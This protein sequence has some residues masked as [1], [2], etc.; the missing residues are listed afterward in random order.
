MILSCSLRWPIAVITLFLVTTV[1]AVEPDKGPDAKDNGPDAKSAQPEKKHVAAE[2]SASKTL[3]ATNAGSRKAVAED[4]KF[5]EQHVRPLLINKCFE[6]HAGEES[7]GGLKLDSSSAL[8]RGGDSGAL[9]SAGDPDGSLLVSAIRYDGL[10]MPPDEQLSAREQQIIEKWVQRGGHWPEFGDADHS[11]EEIADS[12]DNE[13]WWAA[14][15]IRPDLPEEIGNRG[16]RV[17]I[18]DYINDRLRLENL[19]R[20]PPADRATLIRRLSYDL[21][22][23]PPT[24]EQVAEF[25][26]DDRVDAYE[27]WVDR[28]FA[29]PRY[30]ERMGRLW[31]DLVRYADSD[32]WRQDAYRS[33]AWPYRQWV[34]DAFN[35]KLP[36]DQFVAMQIAGDEIAPQDPDAAAAVGFFR[37]GIYEYNQRNAEGQWQDIVDEI[38]DVTADVFLATGLACA[39]CHDHKFDP[40]PRADYFHLRSVFEPLTFVDRRPS[41]PAKNADDRKRIEE[42]TAELAEIEQDAVSKLGN[43]VVDKFPLHVQSWY[44]KPVS[45]RNSYE[46]QI[47]YM[48]ARQYF[49]EGA[50]GAKVDQKLGKEKAARRKEILA[51]LDSL[52]ANPYANISL[53]T[54]R[55]FDGPIRPTRLPGRTSGAS[56]QPRTPALFESQELKTEP[57][58]DA[59]TSTGRRS[60]LAEWITSRD[61]PITARVI[62]NR[63]WQYH[64]GTG[65]VES[66]NDFGRLGS[67]PSHPNLL[68]ALAKKLM[69]SQWD[70]QSIQRS[71]VVSST[72]KQSASH[73]ESQRLQQVDA[74]NRLVWHHSVRRLDAEQY[75]D[76]LLVAMDTMDSTYGGPSVA[77]TPPRRSLYLR[78]MR[79]SVDEM[80][81]LLDCPPGV[82]GTAKRDVT[83]TAPQ[84]LMML[85]NSRILGVAKKFAQRVRR[86][87]DARESSDPHSD[88]VRQGYR[89]LTGQWPPEQTIELLRGQS[90][91]DICHVLLNANAFLFVE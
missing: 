52:G 1:S 83:V 82:V 19:H 17:A 69:D 5:F 36:Y 87:V 11:T 25:E 74:G 42:F 67:P 86:D 72:Y 44:R 81:S 49:D 27:R 73:P 6:C 90:D 4:F 85:N 29:D 28:F 24:P 54:V 68:D 79:N 14:L 38:T 45:Q 51:Q 20:A 22:G 40:I 88:F 9:L 18:D 64:F 30:G 91:V 57:P 15:P 23:V 80:L 39:K 32:G 12:A 53:L 21:L 76:S 63:I 34:V 2:D 35:S 71:I 61:N 26:S 37:L 3:V 31:L 13:P 55:D 77:G 48:V 7:E 58:L 62:V 65:L 8:K 70:L 89:I 33:G 47:A 84:S 78:R 56:F 16:S 46:N 10:E 60:A 41:K 43:S 66:P 75:R 59:P 50:T